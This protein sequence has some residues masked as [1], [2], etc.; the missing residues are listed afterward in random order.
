MCSVERGQYKHNSC[1]HIYIY[2]GDSCRQTDADTLH[3][4]L[5]PAGTCLHKC[6]PK[7]GLENGVYAA[8][9][10]Y[11][12]YDAEHNNKKRGRDLNSGGPRA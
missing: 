6:Q 7:C 9:G 12:E 2:Y 3:A 4:S 10:A 1:Q 11:A 5:S 8:P